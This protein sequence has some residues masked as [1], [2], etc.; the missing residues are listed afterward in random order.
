MRLLFFFIFIF[1]NANPLQA[2]TSGG[3]DS[4]RLTLKQADSLFIKNNL[5]LLAE[6]FRIDAS[7]AQV[8]QAS[9][10]DNPTVTAELSTYNSEARRVLDVGRQGQKTLAIEQLLYTAGKR[11][12]RIALVSEAAQL[13][14]FELLDL[15]RG[16]R[17][18]LRSRFYSIYFQQKTLV[19]FDQQL[20]T[21]QSTVAAYEFQY[22][23][24][25]VSLRELLRLKAL[26]FRLSNDRTAIVF[27]L[28][29]DQRALRTLLSVDQSIKPILPDETLAVYHIPSQPDDTLQ[30]IALRNRPD[31][32]GTISL[33]R[34]AELNHTLQRALAVPDVRLGANYDQAGSYI[35]NYVGLSLSTD[36]PLFN[37]NQGAIRAARS[38][39]SYQ[40]QLQQQKVMQIRNEVA[41]ALQKV[42][43]VERRVQAV[44]QAFTTQFDQLNQGV[45]LSFQKGNITLLEF[46]DLVEA[47]NDSIS[48]LNRL[49]AD[50]VSAY[51]ELNYLLG[52]DLFN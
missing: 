13:T 36:I 31:L 14:Q 20:V 42:R 46:V 17:F 16:L 32:K 37:R 50:R 21:L 5:L 43:E 22:T 51:E 34:Q 8:L 30:Q 4:L 28:A 33:T 40:A 25:N 38:Q 39:I 26:L 3:E 23:R 47:Y 6:R 49:R 35:Q 48:N 1:L 9:L 7:Q 10:Y 52:D 11:N 19:R 27:Q 29:D 24:Q 44:E 41:T 18:D 45:L 12:K 2:Q 15:L